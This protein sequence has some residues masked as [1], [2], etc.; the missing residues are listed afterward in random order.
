[1]E[2]S[3]VHCTLYC[4]VTL[5]EKPVR[6]R[7]A[8][9]SDLAMTCTNCQVE[10]ENE[11]ADPLKCSSLGYFVLAKKAERKKSRDSA[12][13]FSSREESE[14]SGPQYVKLCCKC[15]NMNQKQ[16]EAV[17]PCR[18]CNLGK[19]TVVQQSAVAQ[20][21]K[22]DA[23]LQASS[24]SSTFSPATGGG[25]NF[26][27]R[28]SRASTVVAG[29]MR[30]QCRVEIKYRSRDELHCASFGYVDDSVDLEL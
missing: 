3:L 6:A 17:K 20:A 7:A 23:L 27:V 15:F 14:R 24:I 21:L 29:P 16:H 10:I 11:A 5:L 18:Y 8:A 1:M 13:R 22:Q 12:S 30:C 25:V 2:N 19:K 9:V 28:N 26:N 4:Q